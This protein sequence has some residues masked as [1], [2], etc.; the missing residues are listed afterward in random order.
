MKRLLTV[1]AVT[2]FAQAAGGLVLAQ[3]D[4]FVGTWK[5]NLTKSKFDPGPA[6]KSQTRTWAADG[7]VRVEGVDAAGKPMAYEYPIRAD[8][9]D[10][11]TT[12]PVPNSADSISS[13]RIDA[14]TIEAT[15]TRR[16]KPADT[17]RFVV[18]RD[19]TVLTM[20]VKGTLP[21]GNALVDLLVWDKQQTATLTNEQAVAAATAH[22]YTAL[23]TMFTGD[24]RPMKDAWSRAKDITYMGPNGLYLIG[25]DK[26]EQ[27]WN[28]QTANKLGGRVTPQQLHTVVGGDLAAITCIESGE[29]IVNGKKETVQ[30]RSSTLFRKENG[31]WKVIGHQTDPLGYMNR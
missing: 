11:P 23:N 14:N 5:L 19:A 20:T 3:S 4:P 9:K 13:K 10:Y 30:I 12:G 26:I 21:N 29:N 28:S 25:W 1:L 17:T 2:L 8:G 15:F 31:A 27:E 7:N 6:P 24:G 22:F 16:G 18:S